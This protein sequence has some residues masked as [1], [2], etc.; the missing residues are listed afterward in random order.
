MLILGTRMSKLETSPIELELNF[1]LRVSLK[2]EEPSFCSQIEYTKL[3]VKK[4][5]EATI[6]W[7][8]FQGLEDQV[9]ETSPG[10][11]NQNTSLLHKCEESTC[12]KSDRCL[13]QHKNI[14]STWHFYP[15]S[16]MARPRSHCHSHSG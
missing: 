13:S 9:P 7:E 10:R 5:G 2:I 6:T 4:G 11:Y 1:A 15:L 3:R 14:L 8:K 12:C 16:D